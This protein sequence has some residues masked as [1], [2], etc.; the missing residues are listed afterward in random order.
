MNKKKLQK[1]RKLLF[2][3]AFVL[4]LGCFG[5]ASYIAQGSYGPEER[6]RSLLVEDGKITKALFSPDNN[7]RSVLLNL[8]NCEKKRIV[9][10]IYTL[11]Q[12]EITNALIAASKR[13]VC[14]ECVVDQYFG[15][16]KYSKVNMLANN[17]IPVWVF[18]ADSFGNG[19]MHNKFCI[20]EDNIY[21]KS[22][23]WT[24]S[25]N[26]TNRADNANQENVIILDNQKIIDRYLNQFEV[27]KNRSSL[28]NKYLVKEPQKRNYQLPD[29]F[30]DKLASKAEAYL[31]KL[32]K[33][34]LAC[35]D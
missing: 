8:I 7:L 25:Y 5:I 27:L 28:L 26:F 29:N 31:F 22:I 6:L 19:L 32:F 30:S 11:T 34:L 21:G 13:G 20:F 3:S 17:Q 18:K 4:V 2:L 1:L 23:L 10:A 35:F 15:T 9:V 33:N 12:K 16:D 14:V 24:G